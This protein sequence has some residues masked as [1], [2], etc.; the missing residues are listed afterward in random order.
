MLRFLVGHLDPLGFIA[1]YLLRG[2]LILHRAI[3]AGIGWDDELPKD[4]MI[5]WGAWPCLLR[6][7][8]EVSIPATVFGRPKP[9]TEMMKA[10]ATSC[11]G[12]VMLRMMPCRAWSI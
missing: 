10:V 7:I 2:K 4:I 1:P 11:M 3:C 6:H 5:D 8:L 12:L 9:R